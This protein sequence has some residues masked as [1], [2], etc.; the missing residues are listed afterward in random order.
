MALSDISTVFVMSPRRFYRWSL[1]S[2]VVVYALGAIA[3]AGGFAFAIG[4]HVLVGLCGAGAE[5]DLDM[6]Y[7]M[8]F[9]WK[10]MTG[11]QRFKYFFLL[12][13]KN[14]TQGVFAPFVLSWYIYEQWRVLR[15]SLR[16]RSHLVV[17]RIDIK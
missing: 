16:K 13:A 10:V 5:H 12:L 4:V 2:S 6:K 15:D 7:V 14:I 17:T 8:E 1:L 11:I 9:D 3:G